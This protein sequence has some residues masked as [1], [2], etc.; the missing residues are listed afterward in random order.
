MVWFRSVYRGHMTEPSAKSQQHCSAVQV[1]ISSAPDLLKASA[2]CT[3]VLASAKV[4]DAAAKH[5]RVA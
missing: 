2:G 4:T 1:G 3:A 5:V